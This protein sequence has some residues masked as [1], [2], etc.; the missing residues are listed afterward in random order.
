MIFNEN[1]D[2]DFNTA[3]ILVGNSGTARGYQN[4]S[5]INQRIA[6]QDLCIGLLSI[7]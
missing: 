3:W 4:F 7:I 5:P 6:V 1:M 2:A